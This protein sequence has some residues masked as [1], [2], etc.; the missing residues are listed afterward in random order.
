MIEKLGQVVIWS[1]NLQ[2]SKT[3][4]ILCKHKSIGDDLFWTECKAF[5]GQGIPNAVV[6]GDVAHDKL[7]KGRW[8]DDSPIYRQITDLVF[9]FDDSLQAFKEFKKVTGELKIYDEIIFKFK[10]KE[11]K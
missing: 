5:P 4:C 7:F 10:D 6:D 1:R 11:G 9:E 8:S 3:P 2:N